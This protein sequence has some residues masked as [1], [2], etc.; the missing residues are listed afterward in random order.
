MKAK[1]LTKV[2][3]VIRYADGSE[4]P[5]YTHL[6]R[7]GWTIGPEGKSVKVSY[8]E[9]F[10]VSQVEGDTFKALITYDLWARLE[11]PDVPNVVY[12]STIKEMIR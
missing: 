7:D 6:C 12:D 1:H 9:K 11:S 8:D 4:G 3:C 5:G 2:Y 10:V